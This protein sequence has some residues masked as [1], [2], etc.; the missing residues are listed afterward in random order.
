MISVPEN[1]RE[2][3]NRPEMF[4]L[5]IVLFCI[6]SNIWLKLA[7][8]QRFSLFRP[9]RL[10]DL[11]DVKTQSSHWLIFHYFSKMLMMSYHKL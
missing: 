11:K 1:R 7:I 8:I 3:I 6:I 5:R 9:G 10:N 2:S 4:Y